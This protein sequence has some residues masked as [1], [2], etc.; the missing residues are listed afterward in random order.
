[1]SRCSSTLL[2]VSNV[3][4]R[5]LKADCLCDPVGVGA[6]AVEVSFEFGTGCEDVED[7]APA[8]S[9]AVDVFLQGLE[10]DSSL[11]QRVHTI[12]AVSTGSSEAIQPP[13]DKTGAGADLVQE[14]IEFWTG[15]GCAGDGVGEN[16][17]VAGWGECIVLDSCVSAAGGDSCV[18]EERS[19]QLLA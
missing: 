6:L 1:M 7:R 13:N 5:G 3:S 4:G 9:A 10:V 8:R 2:A 17:V 11:L 18:S 15:F 14:L 19:L 16:A 12:N